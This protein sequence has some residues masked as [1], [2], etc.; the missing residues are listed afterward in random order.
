MFGKNKVEDNKTNWKVVV[1]YAVIKIV[2][3]W[4]VQTAAQK[5]LRDHADPSKS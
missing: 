4:A 1:V 5:Y 2:G 3:I